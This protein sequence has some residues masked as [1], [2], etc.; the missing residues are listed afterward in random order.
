MYHQHKFQ[1]VN[2]NT[3]HIG[4]C[5]YVDFGETEEYKQVVLLE[6]VTVVSFSSA[7]LFT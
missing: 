7:A 5:R 4:S 1:K 3:Y 2:D 6:D